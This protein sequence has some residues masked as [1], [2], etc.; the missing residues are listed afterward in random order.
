MPLKSN[1]NFQYNSA[2]KLL[3]LQKLYET[4]ETRCDNLNQEEIIKQLKDVKDF[5]KEEEFKDLINLL[6]KN[7]IKDIQEFNN[8]ALPLYEH[9][10]TNQDIGIL[11]N[12][13]N[14]GIYEELNPWLEDKIN[15]GTIDKIKNEFIPKPKE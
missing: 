9:P 4:I 12:K 15:D 6:N 10:F 13:K 5:L 1:S 3:K 11:L 7:S 8:L 2:I 14:T